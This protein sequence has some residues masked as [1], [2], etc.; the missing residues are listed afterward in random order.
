MVRFDGIRAFCY[1]STEA[2][3]MK[4]GAL[5]KHCLPLALAD[6]AIL[7][8]IRAEATVKE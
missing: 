4:F 1:N 6:F 5:W 7:G 3:W 2:I 8:L